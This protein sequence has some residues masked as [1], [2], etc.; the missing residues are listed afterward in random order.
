M[1]TP[2]LLLLLV[3]LGCDGTDDK[4]T[5]PPDSGP[6]DGGD[7]DTD[8]DTDADADADADTDADTD[9]TGDTSTGEPSCG[10]APQ[11]L[12][13]QDFLDLYEE[14][15]CWIWENVCATAMPCPG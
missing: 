5:D 9:F 4:G 8:S 7:A 15:F 3:V 11:P 10:D 2:S 14:K 1:R 13:E 6:S 12:A